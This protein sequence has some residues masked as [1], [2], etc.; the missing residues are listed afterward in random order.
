M[1][2]IDIFTIFYIIAHFPGFQRPWFPLDTGTPYHCYLGLTKSLKKNTMNIFMAV[3]ITE[4]DRKVTIS[5][6]SQGLR[7]RHA[8]PGLLLILRPEM[9]DLL[10]FSL[11]IQRTARVSQ[12]TKDIHQLCNKDKWAFS[13]LLLI[14]KIEKVF[15]Q[16]KKNSILAKGTSEIG[17]FDYSWSDYIIFI[18][19]SIVPPTA[20]LDKRSKF[21]ELFSR[22]HDTKLIGYCY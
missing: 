3:H 20:S 18:V 8:S 12:T 11:S 22:G 4:V 1:T 15:H 14:W 10:W 9:T 13:V 17:K 2:A 21:N 5:V 6:K 19:P 16:T 7:D